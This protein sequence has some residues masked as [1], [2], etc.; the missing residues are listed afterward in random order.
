MSVSPGQRR[1]SSPSLSLPC[2]FFPRDLCCV[3]VT[4]NVSNERCTAGF[5]WTREDAFQ[6]RYDGLEISI[7]AY[8]WIH[9]VIFEISFQHLRSLNIFFIALVRQL[10]FLS[11]RI[12]YFWNISYF[13][14][15][16]LKLKYVRNYLTSSYFAANHWR[17][18]RL[19]IK[20]NKLCVFSFT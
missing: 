4:G 19:K 20:L 11:E 12:Q 3:Y 6:V 1:P 10:R 18:S 8:T 15:K 17:H 5:L 13:E 9:N 7:N 14:P 16:I 2:S